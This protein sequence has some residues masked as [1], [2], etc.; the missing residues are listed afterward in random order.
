V[1]RAA[2][3]LTEIAPGIARAAAGQQQQQGLGEQA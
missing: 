2:Q 3:S 1:T